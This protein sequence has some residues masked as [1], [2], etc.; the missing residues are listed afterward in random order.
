MTRAAEDAVRLAARFVAEQYH[1]DYGL[2]SEDEKDERVSEVEDEVG[3]IIAALQ[4][5]P[6]EKRMA[7]MGMQPAAGTLRGRPLFMER[8]ADA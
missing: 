4:Q 1:H 5:L 7:A 2:L 3:P 8:E 6:V